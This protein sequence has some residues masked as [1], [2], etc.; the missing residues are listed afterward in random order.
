MPNNLINLILAGFAGFLILGLSGML[1]GGEPVGVIATIVGLIGGP[2]VYIAWPY[3][4]QK[5]H[6]FSCSKCGAKENRF[7][8]RVIESRGV[9]TPVHRSNIFH[10]KTA[11]FAGIERWRTLQSEQIIVEHTTYEDLR[12]C[13]KC[14]HAQL[15]RT[16]TVDTNITF[17]QLSSATH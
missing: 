1:F 14:E 8:R 7:E 15:I 6:P 4:K 11:N 10:Y 2:V 3:I 17:N 5:V 16:Y 12:K 9:P 13:N